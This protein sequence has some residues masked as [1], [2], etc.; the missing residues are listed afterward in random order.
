L[1]TENFVKN[2]SCGIHFDKQVRRHSIT[3]DILFGL[4]DVILYVDMY[5]NTYISIN[6]LIEVLIEM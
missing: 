4:S 3:T 2:K 5:V 1:K 6:I